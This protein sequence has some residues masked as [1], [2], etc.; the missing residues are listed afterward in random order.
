M[1]LNRCKTWASV[2]GPRG[3]LRCERRRTETDV[4][5][6]RRRGRV[7]GCFRGQVVVV[8]LDWGV[9]RE[10]RKAQQRIGGAR[11]KAEPETLVACHV[12]AELV[13]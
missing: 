2:N 12:R 9:C 5:F 6:S 7:D 1:R 11:G 13:Q 10:R 4:T 8:R 3:R